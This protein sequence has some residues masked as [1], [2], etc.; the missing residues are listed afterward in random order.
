VHDDCSPQRDQLETLCHDY[1]VEFHSNEARFGHLPGDLNVYLHGLSWAEERGVDILVKFSRRFV[2]LVPWQNELSMLAYKSQH[3]TFSGHC[4]FHDYGFRTECL[5]MHVR[6]WLDFGGKEYIDAHVP[7][8]ENRLI[9]AVVHQA[10]GRVQGNACIRALEYEAVNRPRHGSE[11]YAEWK[12]LGTNRTTPRVEVLWH[13]SSKP[14]DY[15]RAL[16]QYGVRRYS[17]GDFHDLDA[18]IE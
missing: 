15:H 2:P 14:E 8:A 18:G 1:G 6:S 10:A 9:E 13:D 4:D 17:D 7:G 11:G 5:G 3:A 12:L 16:V